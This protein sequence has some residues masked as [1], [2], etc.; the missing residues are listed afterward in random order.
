VNKLAFFDAIEAALAPRRRLPLSYS[1]AV[2]DKDG[3]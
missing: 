1:R 2:I 3:Q